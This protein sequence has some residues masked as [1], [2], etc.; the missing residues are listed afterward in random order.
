MIE[1]VGCIF[2][3]ELETFL[4]KAD[5][6]VLPCVIA[7]NGDIDGI[8]TVLMEAMATEIPVISTAVSGIPE[9]VIDGETGLLVPEKDE[10]S[11]AET[12]EHLI[13]NE[14]LR[15]QLGRNAREHV[16]KDF[17][18]GSNAAKLARIFKEYIR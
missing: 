1:I 11:L 10:I 8:P 2:Q 18:M 6:F 14:D 12:M 4:H 13:A 5:I 7:D 16:M 3:E 9:L 15:I 17:S